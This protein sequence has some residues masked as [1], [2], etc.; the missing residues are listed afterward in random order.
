M[1]EFLPQ[2]PLVEAT[3]PLPPH[4]VEQ[5]GS[6]AHTRGFPESG[7]GQRSLAE[8]EILTS[9][10]QQA[11]EHDYSSQLLAIAHTDEMLSPDTEHALYLRGARNL[12]TPAEYSVIAFRLPNY[13]LLRATMLPAFK[14]NPRL[15]AEAIQLADKQGFITASAHA[16]YRKSDHRYWG[17]ATIE[18][19]DQTVTKKTKRSATSAAIQDAKLKVLA[20]LHGIPPEDITDFDPL[21][22][23][24]P[25]TEALRV[26][27]D[28]YGG[29][30]VDQAYC[31]PDLARAALEARHHAAHHGKIFYPH[32]IGALR[33]LYGGQ[34]IKWDLR[35]QS[36]Q[37]PA[38]VLQ[39][40]IFNGPTYRLKGAYGP[41]PPAAKAEGA[42]LI[43]DHLGATDLRLLDS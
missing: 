2:S 37:Q 36:G 38:E 23:P 19:G 9:E 10:E 12:L 4:L 1:P 31:V 6:L 41:A 39:A 34:H 18:W 35:Q 3:A 43:L 27:T 11:S 32:P 7:D 13:P 33:A 22:A 15:M 30:A 21:E 24:L 42:R 28:K 26:Y 8:F 29:H 25:A 17:R 16:E 40:T 5:L 20:T 14:S